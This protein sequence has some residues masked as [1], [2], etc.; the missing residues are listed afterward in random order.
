MKTRT[1][2]EGTTTCARSARLAL[3]LVALSAGAAWAA[4]TGVYDTYFVTGSALAGAPGDGRAGEYQCNM[5]GTLAELAGCGINTAPGLNRYSDGGATVYS[6]TTSTSGAI[7][8]FEA[9]TRANAFHVDYPNDVPTTVIDPAFSQARAA[10]SL[11]TGSLHASVSNNAAGGYVGGMAVADLHDSVRLQVAGAEA[12]TV[13]RVSFQFAVDGTLFDDLQTTI[14][15][16]RGSGNLQTSL[17]LDDR[18]SAHENTPDYWLTAFGEWTVYRG[19]LQSN[20]AG[21]D[22]RGSHVGGSWTSF[23][24]EEMVFDGWLDIIGT[25]A[26]INPTLS[27][28]LSCDIGLQC[29]YGNSA[30]FR[31]TGLPASVSY[32]SGS[33][34]FLSGLTPP[35]PEPASVL[36]FLAGLC[37]LHWTARRRAA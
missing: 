30:K 31:F 34:V 10:A 2:P 33:G 36:L 24:V 19:V 23:G 9:Q 5:Q 25:E 20:Q 17:R 8:A 26:I 35:V 7:T 1:K 14:Y 12:S 27:L 37:G 18:S 13:T 32:T 15:G 29:D 21:L 6:G 28:L 11:A 16:E 22:I 4:P 3:A